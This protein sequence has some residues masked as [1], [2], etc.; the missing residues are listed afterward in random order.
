MTPRRALRLVDHGSRQAA[1]NRLLEEIAARIRT[2]RPDLT[3]EWAH[4]ELASPSVAQGVGAC[5]AAGASEIVVHPYFLGPGSHTRHTI[6]DL[7]AQASAQYPGVTIRVS[8]PLG[9]HDKLLEVVLER[10]DETKFD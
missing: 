3:V 7:V 2:R 8:P 5:V 9:L 4:M 1:A 6:P 10:V